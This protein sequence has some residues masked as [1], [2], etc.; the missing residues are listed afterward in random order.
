MSD[1]YALTGQ[2]I[3]IYLTIA[4]L[5][6]QQQYMYDIRVYSVEHRIIYI[7]DGSV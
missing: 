1:G 5:H 7:R 2:D 6:E 4:K 3:D